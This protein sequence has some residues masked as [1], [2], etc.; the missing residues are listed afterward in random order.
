MLFLLIIIIV[1]IVIDIIIYYYRFK[2]FGYSI[3][4]SQLLCRLIDVSIW[5]CPIELSFFKKKLSKFL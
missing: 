5:Q 4:L 3:E 1:I 2:H